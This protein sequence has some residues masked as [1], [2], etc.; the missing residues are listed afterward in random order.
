M[1]KILIVDNSVVIR[2]M[3]KNLFVSESQITIFE[4]N[5]LSEV[6]NLIVDYKF[7]VVITNIVLS[8]SQNFELLDLLKEENLPTIIFSSNTEQVSLNIKY[9]NVIIRGETQDMMR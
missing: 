5:S 7:F 4:A 9:S 3:L 1:K 2:D 6:K 8:D